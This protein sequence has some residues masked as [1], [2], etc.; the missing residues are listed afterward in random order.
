MTRF[1]TGAA[2]DFIRQQPKDKPMCLV[3]SLHSPHPPLDAP[4]E[5]ATMFDP[6]KL[7]LPA[8][9]P[10]Q[11]F[12]EGHMLRHPDMQR[13]LANYLGK[14]AL[15]DDNVGRLVEAM[16]QRGTWDDALVFFT[17][18]HGEMMG[19]HGCTDQGPLLRG[20]RPRAAC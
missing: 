13:L 4:G 17:A 6:E 5:F 19:S 3:V 12:R 2:I 11:F 1:V 7:T 16:K 9:V 14:I 8:N 15:V 10:E 20:I 18:D